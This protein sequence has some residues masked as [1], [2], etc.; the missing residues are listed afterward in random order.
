V[1]VRAGASA[2]APPLLLPTLDWASPGA[3]WLDGGAP[4][5]GVMSWSGYHARSPVAHAHQPREDP[6]CG[7]RPSCWKG[8][9][10]WAHSGHTIGP[11]CFAALMPVAS[12]QEGDLAEDPLV[13]FSV[14][15][16]SC[17]TQVSQTGF[18]C[19][20]PSPLSCILLPA[21]GQIPV[22]CCHK[23]DWGLWDLCREC[24][25]EQPGCRKQGAQVFHRALCPGQPDQLWDVA[26]LALTA[27]RWVPCLPRGLQL[28]GSQ[29]SLP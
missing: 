8:P 19:L 3:R 25:K 17:K 15:C 20:E 1:F 6:P 28:S 23:P 2:P 21:L 29:V 14:F 13:P 7:C 5:P 12:P 24:A 4:G 27:A 18:H 16:L 11:M 9:P 26:L 10:S 22:P